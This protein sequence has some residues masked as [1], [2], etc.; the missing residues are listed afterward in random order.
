MPMSTV[1]RH[2]RNGVIGLALKS[3][4]EGTVPSGR[5][6]TMSGRVQ[7][8]GRRNWWER[9]NGYWRMSPSRG[10]GRFLKTA[11][12]IFLALGCQKIRRT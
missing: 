7:A 11:P 1:G 6:N 4:W 5:P 8:P 10:V 3:F 2:S 12:A 9:G